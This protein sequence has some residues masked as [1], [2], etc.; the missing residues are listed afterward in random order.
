L[1]GLPLQTPPPPEPDTRHA[2]HLYQVLVCAEAR[3][4]RD[5]VLDGLTERK[6]GTGVHY[7]CVHLHPF[8]RDKYGLA[9]EHFPEATAISA[10]T[11]SLPLSP[12][13]TEADQ[14]DVV[15]ALRELI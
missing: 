2:R 6:I 7:R 8:Y 11:V 5:A 10:R 9:P 14:A 13:V 3:I 15:A 4:G 12:K 1:A